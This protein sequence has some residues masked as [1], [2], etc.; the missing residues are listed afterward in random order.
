MPLIT[1][2]D[3]HEA[4]DAPFDEF[5][6]CRRS[7][8][9]KTEIEENLLTNPVL[10]FVFV[11]SKQEK[12]KYSPTELA[13]YHL[14]CINNCWID[15]F[16][17]FFQPKH[18][19]LG[20]FSVSLNIKQCQESTN[21]TAD[22]ASSFAA[23]EDYENEA[24]PE[25]WK[26][27]EPVKLAFWWCLQHLRM[28]SS[29]QEMAK[30]TPFICQFANDYKSENRLLGIQCI[31]HCCRVLSKK[32]ILSQMG[33]LKVF[34]DLLSQSIRLR[35]ARLTEP[36]IEALID[37]IDCA[38]DEERATLLLQLHSLCL[39]EQAAMPSADPALLQALRKIIELEGIHACRH[40]TRTLILI[41]DLILTLQPDD[42]ENVGLIFDLFETLITHC[43]DRFE[44]PLRN[45]FCGEYAREEGLESIL[46]AI[47][48]HPIS[49][50][51]GG[52]VKAHL[53]TFLL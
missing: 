11:Q 2:I 26:G 52:R 34:Y 47:F 16:V 10:N 3:E 32:S 8:I 14:D 37:L 51:Y 18:Q 12:C 33:L 1:V 36:A 19:R 45:N 40:V 28:I 50:V 38:G 7:W 46:K 49:Q 22:A 30:I 20:E 31:Q 21:T 6:Y 5:D 23:M 13:N 25:H 4:D 41:N 17:P 48:S 15:I 27:C 53:Q 42:S 39:T 29:V 44:K 9:E 35:E 24:D 43:H